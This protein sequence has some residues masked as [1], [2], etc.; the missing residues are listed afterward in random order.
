VKRFKLMTG[1]E[2]TPQFNDLESKALDGVP[3]FDTV[4]H[5]HRCTFTFDRASAEIDSY[6]ASREANYFNGGVNPLVTITDTITEVDGGATQWRYTGVSLKLTAG[7][8]WKGDSITTQT[9]EAT[10]SRKIRVG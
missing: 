5:G 2:W 6:F 8:S 4:P 10:A 7:G 1:F 3:R 9:I